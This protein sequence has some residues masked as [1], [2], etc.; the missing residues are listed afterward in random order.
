[1]KINKKFIAGIIA[2]LLAFILLYALYASQTKTTITLAG[3]P[4]VVIQY[5]DTYEEAGAIGYYSTLFKKNV[6][7]K[8]KIKGSVN[9][10]KV[11]TY[12]LTYKVTK[13]FHTASVTREVIVQD[14]IPPEITLTTDE[15]YFLEDGAEYKEEG[16]TATDNAD[17][18]ITDQV[19]SERVD[20]TIV[21]TVSDASGNTTQVV[22]N[23][24]FADHIAPI[25]T[26]NGNVVVTTYT[27]LDY[28]DPGCTA[29]D[30]TDGDISANVVVEGAVDT[31]TPGTY[32]LTYTVKDTYGNQTVSKRT[33]NV[34]DS[35]TL[36][37]DES[38]AASGKK[39]VYLTFDDGPGPY[40]QQLLDV[41]A[42][43]NV[44]ATFFVTA[45]YTDY[46]SLLTSEANAGHTVAI[47]SYRH[48]YATVYASTAAYYDDLYKMQNII[49]QYTGQTSTIVRFPGGS[50][51]EV[52]KQYCSG[53]MTSLTQSLGQNGFVYFD[54][55]VS[56][57]D[58]GATTD[59]SQI[60]TNI[61]TGIQKYDSSVVLQHDVKDYSV[62]AVEKVI[63]WGLAHG[64]TFMPL[65]T[66]SPVCHH[67]VN[68]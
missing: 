50:S 29:I 67:G 47:H 28:S 33:V 37:N 25:I 9:T 24:R 12:T 38:K 32:T 7:A 60:F 1:M 39:I 19:T 40:T 10:N 51:N 6:S 65:S 22:R 61:T 36:Q 56:S 14:Q 59:T 64:Y 20:N 48:D 31:S 16:Y 34:L 8:I 45:Q 46:M 55:N 27:T 62:A 35:T 23:I 49:K 68:N 15:N 13:H 44:H 17:G 4:Q 11:G 54:W 43:Y 53:I 41:L 21:Y 26:L 18:D 63:I 42:K 5:G 3:E 58:A 57:G 30:E 2:A 66:S 52:S